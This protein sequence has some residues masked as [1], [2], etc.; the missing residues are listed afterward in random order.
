[1]IDPNVAA[2]TASANAEGF[3]IWFWGIGGTFTL[4]LLGLVRQAIYRRDSEITEILKEI[5]TEL[6]QLKHDFN[7]HKLD[8][9]TDYPKTE[10][11]EKALGTQFE[12][13]KS[14][15]ICNINKR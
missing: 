9:A 7:E 12:L 2:Q 10:A 8:V 13:I 3:G 15:I 1:M 11:M 4:F 14:S 5:Q 6:K